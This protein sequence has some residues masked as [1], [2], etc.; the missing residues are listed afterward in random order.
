M[1]LLFQLNG[2]Q[3]AITNI[4]DNSAMNLAYRVSMKTF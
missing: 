2:A 1:T 4:A 3:T